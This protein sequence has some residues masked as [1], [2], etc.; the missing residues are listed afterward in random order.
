MADKVY[1]NDIDTSE[2]MGIRGIVQFSRIA[3]FIEGDELKENIKRQ[4]ERGQKFPIT[5]P[6]NTI[7]L[8]NTKIVKIKGMED[9]EVDNEGFTKGQRYINQSRYKSKKNPDPTKGYFITAT[10][11]GKYLPKTY[12]LNPDTNKY[13]EIVLEGELAVGTPVTIYYNVYE[14]QKG[15][16]GVGIMGIFIMDPDFKY[17]TSSNDKEFERIGLN[18]VSLSQEEID[19]KRNKAKAKIEAS[20]NTQDDF[21]DDFVDTDVK[22]P[23]EQMNDDEFFDEDSSNLSYDPTDEPYSIED[24]ENRGY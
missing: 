19:E 8:S 7:T 10:N 1:T 15:N 12:L 23:F 9:I 16:N 21:S 2:I 11:K 13:E 17:Y 4:K 5:V 24:D 22:T 20:K 14:S 6:Y 18:V 3:S